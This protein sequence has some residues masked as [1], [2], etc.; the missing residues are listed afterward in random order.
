[1]ANISSFFNHF[2]WK[3]GLMISLPVLLILVISLSVFVSKQNSKMNI[4]PSAN[5]NEM[6]EFFEGYSS[7][8]NI[9]QSP[10][11]QVYW[12]KIQ[13]TIDSETLLGD[14]SGV[15]DITVTVPDMREV[16]NE[17]FALSF[18]EASNG[19]TEKELRELL[20]KN[21]IASLRSESK[22]VSTKI[23]M[24][25]EKGEDGWKLI[26]NA[27]WQNAVLGGAEEVFAQ[28]LNQYMD[29]LVEEINQGGDPQ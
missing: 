17:T 3:K 16:M 27:S 19:K 7:S 5:G 20:Q 4:P 25:A 28:Y 9:S 29:A 12:E 21:I 23:K 15:V 18:S 6:L 26:P 2:S 10:V 11:N 8:N 24:D 22:T 13:Y 1:M 14:S